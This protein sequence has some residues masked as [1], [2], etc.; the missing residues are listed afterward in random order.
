MPRQLRTC[1][2]WSLAALVRARKTARDGSLTLPTCTDDNAWLVRILVSA[3]YSPI[4]RNE[5]KSPATG[6]HFESS[7][8]YFSDRGRLFQSDRGR[9]FSLIADGRREARKRGCQCSSIVRDQAEALCREAVGGCGSTQTYPRRRASLATNAR[10][11]GYVVF[12]AEAVAVL[13]GHLSSFGSRSDL[14]LSS[15]LWLLCTTRSRMASASVGSS[16]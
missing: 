11:G 16:R 12:T 5:V 1:P 15:I 7:A 8:A 14:P 10:R 13:D 9:R 4:A 2:R 6:E 3:S